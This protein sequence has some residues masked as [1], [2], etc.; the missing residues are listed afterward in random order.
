LEVS[1]NK[2]FGASVLVLALCAGRP[3]L[4]EDEHLVSRVDVAFRV[5]ELERTQDAPSRAP[6]SSAES[7]DLA[8]R[9]ADLDADP[10]ASGN[11]PAV[12]GMLGFV[13]GVGLIAFLLLVAS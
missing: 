3:V 2:A 8:R 10:R 7:A 12:D 4:G 11:P 1:V 13:A 6:L 9:A 5:S